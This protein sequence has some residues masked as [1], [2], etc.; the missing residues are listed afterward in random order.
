MSPVR[1]FVKADIPQVA[2][3]NRKVFGPPSQVSPDRAGSYEAYFEEV[4]LDGPVRDEALPSLVHAEADEKIVGFLGVVPRRMLLDGQ[5][6]RAAIGSHFVVDPASRGL[7]GLRIIKTFFA[8][9]QDL[10][11]ADHAN[12]P[13]RTLWEGCGGRTALLYSTNWIRPLRPARLALGFLGKRGLPSPLALL[14]RPLAWLA[15]CLLTRVPP[16]P[17]RL[18]ASR[19]RPEELDEA[20]LL[21]ALPAF[22]SGRAL[23]FVH[24]DGALR[25]ILGRARRWEAGGHIHKALLRDAKRQVAGWYVYELAPG[26]IAEVLQIAAARHTVRDVLDHLFHDAWRRGATALLGRLDPAFMSELSEKYCPFYRRGPWTLIH[27]RRPELLDAL[28]RGDAFM[29]RMEGEWGLGFR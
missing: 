3:L 18:S 16:S 28:H 20:A 11:L 29:T 17:L 22:A 9:P 27:S 23:R 5:P 19:L 24:D 8:G 12:D 14:A 4:F 2:E 10:S 13:V 6:V 26:G 15:D 25:W 21:A 1:P 7:A